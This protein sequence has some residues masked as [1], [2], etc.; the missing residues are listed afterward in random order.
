[1]LDLLAHN[2]FLA[3]E[4]VKVDGVS[5]RSWGTTPRA[6]GTRAAQGQAATAEASLPPGRSWK[7]TLVTGDVVS[8]RTI[9][10]GPPLVSVR[11]RRLVGGKKT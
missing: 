2:V 8:V 9:R 7:V 4:A 11:R 3:V 5:S 1:M 6:G 10:E